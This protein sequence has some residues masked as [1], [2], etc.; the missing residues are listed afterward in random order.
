[1]GDVPILNPALHVE[2]MRFTR[3]QDCWLGVLVTPWCMNLMLLPA[4][5]ATW[6]RIA[7]HARLLYHFPAGDLGFL[8]GEQPE[9]GE[10]HS[11]SLYSP[12]AQFPDQDS[13]RAVATAALTALM[14]SP[15]RQTGEL[16]LQL[17]QDAGPAA[18]AT[19][20]PASLTPSGMNKRE[21]FGKLFRRLPP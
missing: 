20:P 11:C 15:D 13:A 18:N 4:T 19:E 7:A 21:F 8:C 6:T 1:M 2:A 17:H 12:M 3:W 9:L 16:P 5:P 10:Y 14:D